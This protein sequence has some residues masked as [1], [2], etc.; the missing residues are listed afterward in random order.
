MLSVNIESIKKVELDIL[1][2]VAE[3]CEKHNLKY[4]LFYGTL[5]GA[6]RHK[7]FIPWDDDIDIIMPREDYDAFVRNFHSETLKVADCF[8]T[9]DY[10]Y[11]FAKVFNPLFPI[12]EKSRFNCNLG[13]YI[14]IFPVDSISKRDCNRCKSKQIKLHKTWSRAISAKNAASKSPIRK[15]YSCF[16]TVKRTQKIAQ[17]ME[18]NAKKHSS[19]D[20]FIKTIYLDANKEGL[21]DLGNDIFD[22]E[23][24][25][26]EGMRFEA[27]KNRDGCLKLLYGNYME[28]PPVEKRVFSHSFEVKV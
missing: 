19:P 23:K 27:P 15:L 3:Y 26:F 20:L 4:A 17:L 11:P 5:L 9:K 22:T 24:I 7:G 21:Q 18:K 14:D 10:F 28:L 1:I 25:V 8:I 6:V 16:F 12:V 13:I 2:E